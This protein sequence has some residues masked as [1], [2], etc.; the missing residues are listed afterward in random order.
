MRKPPTGPENRVLIANR[1]EI[2]VRLINACHERGI[3]TIALF[4]DNDGAHAIDA[5]VSIRLDSPAQYMDIEKIVDIAR[6]GL[7]KGIAPGYGFLSESAAFARAVMQAGMTFIGPSADVL[8]TLGDKTEAKALAANVGVSTL[9]STSA[10]NDVD[11]VLKFANQVGFPV[12]IKAKDGG[13]G[14]GIRIVESSAEAE[15]A[16]GEAINESPSRQVFCEKAAL[17]GF[18][19]VEVQIVGDR[20]GNVRHVFERECS[21]QRRFQKVIEI[22]PSSLTR[23]RVAPIIEASLKLARRVGYIGLGTFEFLVDARAAGESVP[24]YFMECNP[25]IQVEHTITEEVTGIDLVQLLLGVCLDGLNL[26]SI[27]FPHAPLGHAIQS[28]VNTEDPITFAPATGLIS[29]HNLPAGPGVRVDSLLSNTTSYLVSDFFDNMVAKV[30]C[31]GA[32]YKIALRRSVAALRSLRINGVDTN[33]SLLIGLTRSNLLHRPGLIDITTLSNASM[34]SRIVGA[35]QAYLTKREHQAQRLSQAQVKASQAASRDWTQSGSNSG[36]LFRQGDKFEFSLGGG[37]PQLL[38]VT[39]LRRMDWPK[40]VA[41]EFLPVGST[42]AKEFTLKRAQGATRHAK[43]DKRDPWQVASPFSGILVEL[44]VESGDFVAEG[45]VIAV[46]RQMKMEID[47]RSPRTGTV[48]SIPE[49][50]KVGEQIGEA[51]LLC[52][53]EPSASSKAKL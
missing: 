1:G 24:F 52:V 34:V 38:E 18:K 3:E 4:T 5:T 39:K 33:Q 32:T 41:A 17:R 25:R 50:I 30:I 42:E 22:A 43:A 19:H 9:P 53:L 21:L 47:V 51:S 40:H 31:S 28:R 27:S 7:C 44:L 23:D 36:Q 26:E 20:Y 10:V 6:R 13:G 11:G 29:S 35:G 16:F 49:D 12:I 15:R 14:R 37:A 48:K 45:E 8:A 46:L 2:A